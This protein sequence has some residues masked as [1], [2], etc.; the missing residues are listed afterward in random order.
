MDE[1][2]PVYYV[3]FSGDQVDNMIMMYSLFAHNDEERPYMKKIAEYLSSQD[4]IFYIFYMLQ[5]NISRHVTTDSQKFV[6]RGY[7]LT[8]IFNAIK[9]QWKSRTDKLYQQMKKEDRIPTKWVNEYRLYRMIQQR[10]SN[11]IYQYRADWLNAQSLDIYLPTRKIGIEYQGEQHYKSIDFFGGEDDY[12]YRMELDRI[13]KAKAAEQG[14]T[15]LYWSYETLINENSVDAF[16]KEHGIRPYR[17]KE[18]IA[19]KSPA[20][21]G[22]DM[23]PILNLPSHETEHR[24]SKIVIR[25]Y[26]VSGEYLTQY[27]NVSDASVQNSI[28]VSSIWKCINGQRN[29]AGG[30]IWRRENRQDSPMQ[31][32]PVTSIKSA[33]D[34]Q[35][36]SIDQYDTNGN[37]I[38]TFSSIRSAGRSLQINV[39]SI[40]DALKGKQ[41]TA[42]G[43]L[44]KYSQQKYTT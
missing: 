14:I 4:R 16:I 10:V 34:F 6:L 17:D 25:K 13:K 19:M 44:W 32:A 9:K 28:S 23:A 11:A 7:V 40:S 21:N 5:I 36:K 42:G 2:R 8:P 15:I 3:T 22:V 26:S 29:V 33:S 37:Y 31:I 27:N 1:E 24:T 38:Q 35:P 20:P 18:D 39:K 12:K 43:F 41:K 30:Y